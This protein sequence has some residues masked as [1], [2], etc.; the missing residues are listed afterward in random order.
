MAQVIKIQ[1]N[2]KILSWAREEAGYSIEELSDKL[3]ITVNRFKNWEKDGKEI[4]FGMLKKIAN[5]YK[6]QLA[7]FFLPTVPDKIKKPK[8]YRNLAYVTENLSSETL[9]AIRRTFKYIELAK[10][11]LGTKYWENSYSW[12]NSL[13]NILSSNSKINKEPV[14]SWLRQQ[15]EID[16]NEQKKFGNNYA[17]S[18]N[19]WRNIIEN[20]LGLFVFQFSMPIEELDGFSYVLDNYPKAIIINSNALP[21]RKIF[22]LFHELGH[23]LKNQSALCITDIAKDKNNLEIEYECNSFAGMFLVPDNKVYPISNEE[24]L[25]IL[26]KELSVSREVYLRQS[27]EK[28]LISKKTF[29]ELLYQI[30]KKTIIRKNK[31]NGGIPPK[32]KSKSSRGAMF[33]NLVLNAAYNS[34]IDFSTASDVLKLKVNH[35][36]NE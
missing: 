10:D 5:Y 16:I 29:F 14:I 20:K 12:E 2:P 36:L 21:Q 11:I 9:L 33:Y 19:K 6:R 8:D 18:Y 25:N 32:V 27:F 35:I 30:R 15:L 26:A 4:P 13:K 24:E 23:I 31:I 22:T 1:A 34:Q 3:G 17:K 28:G 7:V